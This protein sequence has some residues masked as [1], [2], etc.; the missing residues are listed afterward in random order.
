MSGRKEGRKEYTVVLLLGK[1]VCFLA[2]QHAMYIVL[3]VVWCILPIVPCWCV[4]VV[5]FVVVVLAIWR[6]GTHVGFWSNMGKSEP[7]PPQ[8]AE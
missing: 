7:P 2:L 1:G 3:R 4:T 8:K 6:G 5:V